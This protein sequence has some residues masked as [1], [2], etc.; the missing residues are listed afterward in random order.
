MC[1]SEIQVK[2]IVHTEL[3]PIRTELNIA[4]NWA[5]ALLLGLLT[6]MFGIGIWVGT[7]DTRVS[8]NFTNQEKFESRVDGKLDR[9]ETLLIEIV[10]DLNN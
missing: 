4:K 2:D 10:K 5:I 6:T 9:I 7:I 8:T 3:K 1:V